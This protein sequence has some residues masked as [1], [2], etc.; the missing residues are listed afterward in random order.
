MKT[1]IDEF[2]ESIRG[3]THSAG[4]GKDMAKV[5]TADR[6]AL[7]EVLGLFRKKKYK[8]ALEK[9]WH[10]DTIV[11][12]RIPDRAWSMMTEHEA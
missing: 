9:A 3:W 6:K 4:E 2:A 8:E 5:Y 7:R 1:I 10:L 11:R 12:E